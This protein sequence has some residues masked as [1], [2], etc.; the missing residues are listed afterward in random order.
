MTKK[1]I[2]KTGKYDYCFIGIWENAEAIAT[3]RKSMIA[4]LDKVRIFM[5]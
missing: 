1:Y 3:Q 4:Y 2:A 5:K